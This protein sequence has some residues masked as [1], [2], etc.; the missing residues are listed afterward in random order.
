M[1]SFYEGKK[2][3]I[4]RKKDNWYIFFDHFQSSARITWIFLFTAFNFNLQWLYYRLIIYCF[5]FGNFAKSNLWWLKL[6]LLFQLG[7]GHGLPGIYA[8]LGVRLRD[9]FFRLFFIWHYAWDLLLFLIAYYIS[10]FIL[11]GAA[12]VHFQDFNAE[13]LKCLTI[14][15]VKLNLAKDQC[16][17]Q[18]TS[19][20]SSKND[21]KVNLSTEVCFFFWWL[22]CKYITYCSM[23]VMT[24]I[25]KVIKLAWNKT[26][27]PVTM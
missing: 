21:T 13:V 26:N 25:R 9:K 11:Q 12:V 7:C 20:N 22:E 17:S 3:I 23:G 15:N 18:N 8:C 24:R 16:Q 1:F 10:N 5:S 19:Q 14:P 4:Y 2:R 27:M 6:D